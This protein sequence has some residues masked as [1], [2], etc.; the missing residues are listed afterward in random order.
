MEAPE[1]GWHKEIFD[2]NDLKLLRDE[3]SQKDEP[4]K[5]FAEGC[6]DDGLVPGQRVEN[7]AYIIGEFAHSNFNDEGLFVEVIEKSVDGEEGEKLAK[8]YIGIQAI[9]D[10]ET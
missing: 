6:C 9:K 2:E 7:L 4:I 3:Y 5:T 10:L 1:D 8:S